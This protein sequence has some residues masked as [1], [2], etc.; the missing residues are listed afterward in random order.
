MKQSSITRRLALLAA[1][2]IVALLVSS[3]MLIHDSHGRYA[4][5]ARTGELMSAAVS[6]GNLIHRLQIERGSTAGFLQSKGEKFADVLPKYRSESDARLADYRKSIAGLS[7]A[8]MPGLGKAL[9]AAGGQLDKLADLRER[10]GRQALA[11]PESTAY[12]T[13]TIGAL[14]QAMDAVARHNGDA[15]IAKRA[16]AYQ[17]FVRAKENAGLERALTTAGFAANKVEPAQYRAILDKIHRQ[18][19]LL[20]LFRGMAGERDK[21]QLATLLDGAAAREVQRLRGI[22]AERALQGGFDVDATAW[23]K[24]ITDKIDGMLEI[25]QSLAREIDETALGFVASGRAAV[26]GNLTLALVALALALAISFWVARGVRR[27]LAAVV[28]AIEHTVARDDFTRSVPEEGTLE[29]A[30]AGKAL[31]ALLQKFR[32]II[33]DAKASS[34][35]IADAARTLATTS[36]QVTR[37][38]SAQAE[39]SSS[40]AAAVEQASVSVSE[41]AANAQS[42]NEIVTKARAGVEHALDVMSETVSNVN[43]IADL[44][45]ASGASVGQLE[46]SSR[47]IGGIVQVIKEIADQTNLLALNAAIEAAR[48]GEQGRGF[49]V[50]ADEVRKLAERTSHATE[51]IAGLI[52]DIQSQIGGTVSGMQQANAQTAQSLDFVGSTENALRGIGRDSEEVAMNVRSIA[53][54]IREQDAA[55]H[56]V[57]SNIERIAQMTEENS[58]A[59]ASSS[60]TA[61]HLDELAG[62]LRGAVARYRV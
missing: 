29:T 8:A 2:P 22:M 14:I 24:Q 34:E 55:I 36:D 58:A 25:E 40:V 44:I 23:F 51:E 61:K 3:G 28:E 12:Y 15:A 42:A 37:S 16:G 6:A 53:D 62:R 13:A 39:S 43:G 59:A 20:D 60:E 47:K 45:R 1:V 4:N 19:A 41:T 38:S 21:Q 31:N 26:L 30:R 32:A 10:A 57:A 52:G 48:A 54:A 9:D 17:A 35:S 7:A 5:A 46:Q 27:P 56:Q 18:E 50:V 11:V 49:A 33:A